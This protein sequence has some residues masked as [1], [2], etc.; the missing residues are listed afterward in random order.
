MVDQKLLTLL[1]CPRCHGELVFDKESR[2]AEDVFGELICRI[3]ALA[4]PVK[5]GVPVM[6]INEARELTLEEVESYR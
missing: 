6:L 5:D 2:P 3:D 4:Y 1:A